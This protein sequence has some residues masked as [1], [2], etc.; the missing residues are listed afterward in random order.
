VS[1]NEQEDLPNESLVDDP[2]SL[3]LEHPRWGG[4]NKRPIFVL[5]ILFISLLVIIGGIF[6]V[7][8]SYFNPEA[9][10]KREAEHQRAENKDLLAELG[11]L[12]ILP[13]EEPLIYQIDDPEL[14]VSEQPFFVGAEAGDK[15]IIYP[16]SAKAIIYSR[17]RKMIVNVGPVTFD[18]GQGSGAGMEPLSPPPSTTPSS[19][20]TE[21]EDR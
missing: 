2:E 9:V 13:Q 20:T 8:R 10:T 15:L 7:H 21:I 16:N 17:T 1:R 12:I 11:K 3:L 19:E 14:L 6:F 18:E 5:P 4:L